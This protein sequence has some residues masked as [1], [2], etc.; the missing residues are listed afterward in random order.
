MKKLTADDL[1]ALTFGEKVYLVKGEH[2]VGY[3]YVGRMPGSE[4]R[5]LIFSAGEDLIHLYINKATKEFRGDWYSGP[6]DSV[7]V[8]N[9]L[10]SILE[11]RIDSI[12]RTYLK[13][14]TEK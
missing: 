14:K 7:F 12:K 4:D 6:Y 9:L 8:G 10:I 1:L 2:I 13:Q 5:Y 3:R 11:D